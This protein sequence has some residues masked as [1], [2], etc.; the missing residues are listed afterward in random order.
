MVERIFF[1]ER[2]FSS[3]KSSFL[4]GMAA[5][6]SSTNVVT[7]HCVVLFLNAKRKLVKPYFTERDETSTKVSTY[8]LI[9]ADPCYTY[10]VLLSSTYELLG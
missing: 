8:F 10:L 6:D 5:A 2:G 3:K 9:M 1:F 7:V 4:A